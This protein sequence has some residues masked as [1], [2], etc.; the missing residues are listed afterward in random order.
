MPT[1]GAVSTNSQGCTLQSVEYRQSCIIFDLSPQVFRDAVRLSL[2]QQVSSF[3]RTDTGVNNSPTLLTREAKTDLDVFGDEVV[4]IGG[5]VDTRQ[6][7][8]KAGL[9]LLPEWMASSSSNS[10]S[11]L[12]VLLQLT[13]QSDN[14]R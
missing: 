4:V 9:P 14:A 7:G 12:L 11:E 6:D 10:A 1:A 3:V 13:R 8:S 5:L 2:S